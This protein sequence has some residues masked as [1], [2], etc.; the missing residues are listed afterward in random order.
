MKH[1]VVFSAD[2]HGN[3]LQYRKL[4]KFAISKSADSLIIGGD[5]APLKAHGKRFIYDQRAFL[6]KRLPRI[7]SPLKR[8]L[9]NCQVYLIMGNDDC[10]CNIDVLEGSDY[11][12]F[13]SG[14]RLRLTGDF[15][16]VGYSYVPITPFMLKDWE[17]FHLSEAPED[18]ALRYVIRKVVN[19]RLYGYRSSL[20]GLRKFRFTKTMEGEYSIQK[21][22]KNSIYIKNPEKTVYVI[23]TAPDNTRLDVRYDGMHVGSMAVRLFIEQYQPY[24]T[25]HGHIH[26]TVAISG[27][28]KE[29]IGNSLCLSAGNDNFGNYKP[30][31]LSILIF[32]LYNLKSV[33][34]QII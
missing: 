31:D 13:I 7:L 16:I 14:R 30:N 6:S 20:E 3:E 23:H 27:E 18:L 9:P 10:A 12:H 5:L 25:L 4:V 2:L 28:F 11:F 8:K 21:D 24:L 15:D 17:K 32:D 1:V 29:E 19:Y 22:L 34:R 33:K 26:E